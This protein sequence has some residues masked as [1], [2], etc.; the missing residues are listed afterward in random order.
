MHST[1]QEI[2]RSSDYD[3]FVLSPHSTQKF[4]NFLNN[5]RQK[6]TIGI[7]DHNRLAF[8]DEKGDGIL[9]HTVYRKET[10]TNRYLNAN[11]HHHP[12]RK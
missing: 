9:N 1:T 12:L 6:I 11:S 2:H 3:R 5:M 8:L 7:K 10:H 4:N